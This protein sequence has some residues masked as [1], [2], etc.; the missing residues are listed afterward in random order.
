MEIVRERLE[1]EFELG[2]ISTAP[3]VVY[4]VILNNGSELM[5][6]N[7]TKLPVEGL[8]NH[9]EEPLVLATV[10]CPSEYVGNVLKLCEDRRG[11][12]AGLTI[13]G[14]THALLNYEIPLNEIVLDFYD[15]LKSVT[16]GY[17]SFDYELKGYQS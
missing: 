6:D 9:I 3:T 1:R 12:Q 15:R 17:A 14:G 8:V 10:H 16:R 13:H 5:V 4:R 2:L 7:P 11:T